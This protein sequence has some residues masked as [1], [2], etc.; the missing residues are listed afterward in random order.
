[1]TASHAFPAAGVYL[2]SITVADLCRAATISFTL[3]K[4]G[5]ALA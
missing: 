2:V 5:P 4:C 1:V 3:A